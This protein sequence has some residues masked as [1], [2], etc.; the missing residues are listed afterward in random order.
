MALRFT[1]LASGSAGNASLV[2]ADDFGLLLEAAGLVHDYQ[3]GHDLGLSRG[4]RCLPLPVRHDG[5]E[6]FGFRVE[7]RADLF[8]AGSALAYASDL[9]CWDATLAASLADVDL[10]ALEFNHDVGLELASGRSPRL[11]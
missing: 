5:G 6:T 10:L 3:A 11:I 4:L 8:G 7:A 9:G 1:V 2:E